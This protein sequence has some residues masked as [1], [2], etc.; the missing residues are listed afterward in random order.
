M[1]MQKQKGKDNERK[2]EKINCCQLFL[3]LRKLTGPV[4]NGNNGM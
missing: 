3:R 2:L 1:H 4:A